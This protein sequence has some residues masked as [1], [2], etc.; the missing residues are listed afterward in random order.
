MALSVSDYKEIISLTKQI[1]EEEKELARLKRDGKEIDKAKLE[2]LKA[3]LEVRRKNNEEAES[4]YKSTEKAYKSASN[5]S[6]TIIGSSDSLLKRK[7]LISQY[8]K[9]SS[10]IQL[11]AADALKKSADF[12]D[13]ILRTKTKSN[14]LSFNSKEMIQ[15]INEQLEVINE[16][17]SEANDEQK[18]ILDNTMKDLKITKKKVK[19]MGDVSDEA[20][21]LKSAQDKLKELS[22][23]Y[24]DNLEASVLMIKQMGKAITQSPQLVGAVIGA[25]FGKAI[26]Y[27][28]ARVKDM[29]Q[30]IGLARDQAVGLRNELNNIGFRTKY[31]AFGAD[32]YN[33]ILG[34]D[35]GKNA[36]GLVNEFGNLSII[37]KPL[38]DRIG[39]FE[40]G[41]MV[42]GETSGK[43]L[44]NFMKIRGESE[45][46]A[47]KSQEFLASL[48]IANEIP[49]AMLMKDVSDN[50][51]T[52]AEFSIQGTKNIEMAAT[53]ARRLGL[54]LS[55]SAK[56]ANSLLDFESSIEKEMSASLLVG[57]QLNYNRARQLALEG[58]IAGATQDIMSQ[59]GGQAGFARLNVIQRRALAESIGVSVEEL[60]R[61]AS[62]K[63]ELKSPDVES[64]EQLT[65]SLS[66]AAN[67]M[68]NL[69]Q[70]FST[71]VGAITGGIGGELIA[72]YIAFRGTKD[73]A[74]QI[75]MSLGLVK[76]PIDP[77]TGKAVGGI[78]GDIKNVFSKGKDDV[79]GP[80][81]QRR[82]D[83]RR[84]FKSGDEARLIEQLSK[85]S[86]IDGRLRAPKGGI[87]IGG[88]FY[89]GGQLLPSNLAGV[90][91][92][93][94]TPKTPT[95]PKGSGSKIPK[96]L[97]G[98][99]GK[100]GLLAI[101]TEAFFLADELSDDTLSRR[102]KTKTIVDSATGLG[103]AA[104][105]AALGATLGSVVPVVGTAIGGI[106]GGIGGYLFGEKVGG[107]AFDYG[108]EMLDAR[109][110]QKETT[111]ILTKSDTENTNRVV[112]SI[113]LLNMKMNEV[114]Q[115][116]QNLNPQRQ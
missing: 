85:Q 60:S 66:Y 115:E 70:K 42:S 77:K 11:V 71:A 113:D 31:F 104:A 54:N 45:E 13:T 90:G 105:G 35:A 47:M 53:Q 76:K 82:L 103:G 7:K 22:G 30:D 102:D 109:V 29:Q 89:K 39:L 33:L 9:S 20:K 10:D 12:E 96:G 78:F 3:Q 40:K 27:G 36:A 81:V 106:L 24:L 4:E 58:N 19:A 67:A 17:Y 49:V 75:G 72:S 8:D 86:G 16:Q 48:A 51:E 69:A 23:G 65:K 84:N 61:L 93:P 26:S 43:L 114:K 63:V 57:K 74:K 14:M 46:T 112:E 28:I 107:A 56:I 55:T 116:I 91:P 52:F 6:K 94:V 110:E 79:I 100:G 44:A 59:L 2:N 15:E 25:G 1:K 92:S 62:G 101:G 97:R 87:N 50:S 41:L 32:F 34:T 83:F 68:D 37:S 88:K 99:K 21:G 95:T 98:L 5:L 111:D 108:A 64:R 38:S 73:I 80:G 18:E